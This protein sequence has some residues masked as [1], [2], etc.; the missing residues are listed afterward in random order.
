MEMKIQLSQDNICINSID[1]KGSICDGPGIRTV[2]YLQGCNFHC[3][4]CHNPQTWD[5]D[6]GYIIP[7]EELFEKICRNSMYKRITISGGEPLLQINAV[8]QLI[9]LLKAAGFDIALYTGFDINDVPVYILKMLNYV[10]CGKYIES[11]RSTT[12]P[13]VGSSNQIFKAVHEGEFN[14]K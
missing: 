13:Y 5:M 7:V 2:I 1:F 14:E 3:V 12:I 10:K 6:K 4:G 9:S 8:Y 11:L